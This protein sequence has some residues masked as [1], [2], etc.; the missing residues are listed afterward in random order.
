[1]EDPWTSTFKKSLK[2]RGVRKRKRTGFPESV[3][4]ELRRGAAEPKLDAL[5]TRTPRQGHPTPPR[6]QKMR[7]LVSL[8]RD[9]V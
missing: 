7:V 9:L 2:K 6:V 5:S 8:E 1:M 4:K 3:M